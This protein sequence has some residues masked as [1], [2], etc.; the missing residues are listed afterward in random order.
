M[1]DQLRLQACSLVREGRYQELRDLLAIGEITPNCQNFR[2]G[3]APVHYV[4]QLFSS[5]SEASVEVV[6]QTVKVLI[7]FGADFSLQASIKD[8]QGRVKL[9][10]VMDMV[11]GSIGGDGPKRE[12][13]EKGFLPN[14]EPCQI[15]R[16]LRSVPVC[17]PHPDLIRK[18]QREKTASP[19]S[20]RTLIRASD[21]KGMP[22]AIL[23]FFK[24][25][26]G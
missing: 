5:N 17:A 24:K 18:L 16:A 6:D 14:F 19:S 3:L 2:N 9:M 8:R 4:A 25:R 13:Y 23:Q 7:E 20:S 10:S 15:T 26:M 12:K 1:T 22:P 21:L 11:I